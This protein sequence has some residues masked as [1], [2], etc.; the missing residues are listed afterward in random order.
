MGSVLLDISRIDVGALRDVW[1][2]S[3]P[4]REVVLWATVPVLV[5]KKKD[6]VGVVHHVDQG[7]GGEQGD[8]M[9]LLLFSLG[10]HAAL[11]AV[12]GRL[13]WRAFDGVLG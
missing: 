4:I 2:S 13:D 3:T 5:G 12:K 8:A 9:M 7:E 6:S 10:Q 11:Q 1:F